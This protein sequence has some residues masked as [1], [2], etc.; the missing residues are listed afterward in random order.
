MAPHRASGLSVVLGV[1]LV[2]QL[3]RRVTLLKY[4]IDVYPT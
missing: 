2:L 3:R 1:L 4:Y